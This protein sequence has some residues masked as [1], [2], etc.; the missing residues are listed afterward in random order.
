MSSL[1]DSATTASSTSSAMD[2]L[3]PRPP[4]APLTPQPPQP[5]LPP[6][7]TVQGGS[8][9]SSVRLAPPPPFCP[10]AATL[11]FEPCVGWHPRRSAVPSVVAPETAAVA[12]ALRPLPMS[13]SRALSFLKLSFWLVLSGASPP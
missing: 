10:G 3:P 4:P 7:H 8:F 13:L 2:D 9:A 5:Q 6:R 11:P 12:G 1:I